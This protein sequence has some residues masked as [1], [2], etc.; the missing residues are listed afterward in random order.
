MK[1]IKNVEAPT[2]R[3]RFG[4]VTTAILDFIKSDDQNIKFECEDKLEARKVY[5]CAGGAVRTHGY[6]VKVIKS[7]NDIYVVRKAE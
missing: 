4:E 6:P 7:G 3:E 2:K 1:I 5:S